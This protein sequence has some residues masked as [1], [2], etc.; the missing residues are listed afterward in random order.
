MTTV[1]IKELSNFGANPIEGFHFIGSFT[2][3]D[4]T[5]AEKQIA[6]NAIT[7][8]PLAGL[9]RS[10]IKSGHQGSDDLVLE[11]SM[12]IDTDI[13]SDNAFATMP[14]DLSLELYRSHRDIDT[15]N[16]WILYWKGPVTSFKIDLDVCTMR[17]PSILSILL[18]GDI[19][20]RYYQNTCN[21]ILYDT[22]C[23]VNP[24]S[25]DFATTIDNI[26]GRDLVVASAGGNPTGF[27]N[28]GKA[29][30]DNNEERQ[31]A[32]HVGTSI[33]LVYP[34]ADAND[35]DNVTLFAGCNLS[36]ST[37]CL[38]KFNNQ[39]NFGGMPYIPKDNP[40]EGNLG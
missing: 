24:A 18:T 27:F 12:P 14:P 38:T 6:I 23:K 8:E 21:H 20:N 26:S 11:V 36:Y 13:V 19:P 37:D 16:E 5:S 3:Y 40:F 4:Y 32:R 22:R 30:L 2:N 28:A 31:I 17:V 7:F 9:E 10:L 35:G 1:S 39:I 15:V 25:F 34:F 33:S 29:V